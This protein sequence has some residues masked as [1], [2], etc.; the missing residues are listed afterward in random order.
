MLKGKTALVTG[1]TSGI[2]CAI[3]RELAASGANVMLTGRNRA[4]GAA[5]ASELGG[6]FLASRQRRWDWQIAPWRTKN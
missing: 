6:R 3:P 2:G 4:A 5:L 1:A